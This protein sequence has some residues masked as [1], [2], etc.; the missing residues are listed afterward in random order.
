MAFHT[1][2][3][4]PPNQEIPHAFGLFTSAEEAAA[5]EDDFRKI[6][7]IEAGDPEEHLFKIEVREIRTSP[8]HPGQG[9]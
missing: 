2:L 7:G 4:L 5:Y 9:W 3:V 8:G 1:L 6:H